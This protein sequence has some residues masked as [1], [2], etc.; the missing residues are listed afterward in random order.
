[1]NS[2]IKKKPVTGFFF[3]CIIYCA[4]DFNKALSRLCFGLRFLICLGF[5]CREF[6][7]GMSASSSADVHAPG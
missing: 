4:D 2:A 7:F 3:Y 6:L 5:P 1:M